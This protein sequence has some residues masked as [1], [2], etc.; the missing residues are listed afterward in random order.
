[1]SNTYVANLS[2]GSDNTYENLNTKTGS[3][4]GLKC[5][6]GKSSY[7]KE[8]LKAPAPDAIVTQPLMIN[9]KT[10][11]AD[12][13]DVQQY[14]MNVPKKYIPDPPTKPV[15]GA[16]GVTE[17]DVP[18]LERQDATLQANIINEYCYY[19]QRYEVALKTFLRLATSRVDNSRSEAEEYLNITKDLNM[20]MNTLLE[21]V[22]Y[23][24]TSRVARINS[25]KAATET[26][27]LNIKQNMADLNKAYT[28]L[29]RE[30]AVIK[31]QKEMA[32]YAKEKNN[33]T[34]N[35]IAVWAAINVMAIGTIFYVYRN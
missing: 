9:P 17:I 24:T 20:K 28:F 2:P 35:Q 29:N 19:Q 22:N 23:L 32:R 7:T 3:Q 27:N 4:K 30:N 25:T 18:A 5:P 8:E 13:K 33:Y 26:Y 6:P 12:Y 11:R 1:M 21:I 10:R 14:V 34:S 15:E 31:T 16:A